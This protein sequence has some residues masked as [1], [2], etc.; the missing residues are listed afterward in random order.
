MGHATDD[1]ANGKP[2][3]TQW[4]ADLLNQQ[5]W[6]WGKDVEFPDDNL[7]LRFG[8]DRFEKPPGMSAASMYRLQLSPETRIVLRG[9]G[10]FC[11]D[12]RWGGMFIH[13]F[14]FEPKLC[15][16]TDLVDAWASSDLPGLEFPRPNQI[17][18]CKRLLLTL[19]DWIRSY[20]TWIARQ[21]GPVYRRSTLRDW[22]PEG[23]E[24]F[25]AEQMASAWRMLTQQLA[26]AP[27][28]VIQGQQQQIS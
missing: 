25:A 24:V 17:T 16:E 23:K 9:F 6:C 1:P 4:A 3:L 11:G 8:F 15:V 14:K 7:L 13:R 20:E 10:V 12:D 27:D 5:I 2:K 18:S 28:E 26:D 19:T 21:L 22:A